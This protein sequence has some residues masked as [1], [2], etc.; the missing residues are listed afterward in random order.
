VPVK[1]NVSACEGNIYSMQVC[2]V[3]ANALGN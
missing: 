3:V 1:Q 2:A